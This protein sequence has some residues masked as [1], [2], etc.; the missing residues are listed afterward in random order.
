VVS[1]DA[2]HRKHREDR[3][4][5]DRRRPHKETV[6]ALPVSSLFSS[7]ICTGLVAA[8]ASRGA[9]GACASRPAAAVS[10]AGSC[11]SS[12]AVICHNLGIISFVRGAVCITG[13]RKKETA[14]PR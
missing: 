8:A 10:A 5:K 3:H 14:V 13:Y 4:Q 11:I 6:S 1:Q 7:H 9:L 2:P 12:I